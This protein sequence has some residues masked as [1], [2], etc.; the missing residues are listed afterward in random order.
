MTWRLGRH[1]DVK[2][3]K[4]PWPC[5]RSSLFACLAL[6]WLMTLGVA[7]AKKPDAEISKEELKALKISQT[8]IG[9]TISDFVFRDTVGQH[10]RLSEYRGKPLV[11]SFIYTACADVCP[12]T[13][14]TLANAVGVARN[15]LGQDSF[16]VVTVGF[17]AA[18]DNPS[19]MLAFAR[20]HGIRDTRWKFLSGDL[21]MVA[22]LSDALGF[23]F[24]RSPKGFDHLTQT[25]IID[26][27]GK[28]YRQV[29]GENFAT[30]NFVEPLKELLYETA[31]PFSSLDEL[32]KKVRL[33][34]TLYDPA[35][36][37]YRF[38]YSLFVKIAIGAGIVL[39]LMFIVFSNW[40]RI[41]RQRHGATKNET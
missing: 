13:T 25:T 8:A 27:T 37:K 16:A 19:R 39:V 31:S 11:V 15:T 41:Y 14:Q 5:L 24:Y 10:V 36:D 18:S 20:K 38:N 9:R 3:Y 26:G 23:T 17:D 35:Q 12:V 40:W 1:I 29:Y 32:V 34:C 30:P 28:V 2:R 7:H 4:F 6:A 33:F 22:G 21:P